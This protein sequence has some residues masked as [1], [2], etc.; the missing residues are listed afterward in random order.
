MHEAQLHSKSAFITLTMES[1]ALHSSRNLDPPPVPWSVDV[2]DWQKFAR[3]LRKKIGPFRFLASGE[4]GDE[5]LRPHYHAVLFGIDFEDKV[6]W[7]TENGSPLFVS[8]ALA[9]LWP[10]GMHTIGRVTFDS[11][12][13]VAKYTTK[14]VRGALSL[15]QYQREEGAKK[16]WV[17]EEFALMSRRPGLGKNWI[18]QF[19]EETFPS[20][21]V[22]SNGKEFKPPRYYLKDLEESRPD[23]ADVLKGRRR[24]EAL[25]ALPESSWERCRVREEVSRSKAAM[26]RKDIS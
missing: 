7:K 26:I 14:Q 3:R 13:Y 2:R 1:G 9:R 16:W 4:Y 20:D 8:P 25:K 15:L 22:V 10:F 5:K 6:F 19:S 18:R 11:A 12:A 17:R 23:L 21:T 24:V